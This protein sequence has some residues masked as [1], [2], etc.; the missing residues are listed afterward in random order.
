MMAQGDE[1]P[2]SFDVLQAF[3][4]P[5]ERALLLKILPKIFH[6][7]DVNFILDKLTDPKRPSVSGERSCAKARQWWRPKKIAGDNLTSA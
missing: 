5:Q 4:E 1:Q 6:S 3:V 2:Q 7:L